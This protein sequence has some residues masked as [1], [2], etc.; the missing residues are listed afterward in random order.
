MKH[1]YDN[2]GRDLRD[3][4]PEEWRQWAYSK[5]RE[6]QRAILEAKS[7]EMTDR[8]IIEA[9]FGTWMDGFPL[10]EF[11]AAKTDEERLAIFSILLDFPHRIPGGPG[12]AR[13]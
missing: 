8:E 11:L 2:H 1:Y 10:D 5:L 3:L 7:P 6:A 4:S 12:A 9:Q 13:S